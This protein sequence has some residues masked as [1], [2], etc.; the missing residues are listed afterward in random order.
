MMGED[1]TEIE[2]YP[3]PPDFT[4]GCARCDKL[5]R[6]RAIACICENLVKQGRVFKAGTRPCP[7]CANPVP[8]FVAAEFK[9]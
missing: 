2:D 7:R 8:V 6:I 4:T 9:D 5:P 1:F 3:V